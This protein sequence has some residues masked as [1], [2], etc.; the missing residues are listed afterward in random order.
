M[1]YNE[2]RASVRTCGRNAADS[3]VQ[4]GKVKSI[5]VNH[6][7]QGNSTKYYIILGPRNKSAPPTS[8]QI[9]QFAPKRMK[10]RHR[11]PFLFLFVPHPQES[12]FCSQPIRGKVR[13]TGRIFPEHAERSFLDPEYC[14]VAVRR[15]TG[16]GGGG[17]PYP[18][19]D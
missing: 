3:M 8:Q 15:K 18:R 17:G 16:G 14:F 11:H 1:A 4:K 9:G 5:Y 13:R 10:Y 7:S 2:M 6:P 19:R 12:S